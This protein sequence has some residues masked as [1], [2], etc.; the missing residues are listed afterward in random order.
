MDKTRAANMPKDNVQRAIDKAS[1]VGGAKF[2]EITY[3]GYSL[4]GLLS[5]W[6]L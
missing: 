5:W 3:E 2:E 1:G 4:V 6:P